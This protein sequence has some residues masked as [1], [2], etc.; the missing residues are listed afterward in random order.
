M[1]KIPPIANLQN[2]T[3]NPNRQTVLNMDRQKND[4]K[5]NRTLHTFG[6]AR[7]HKTAPSQNQKSAISPRHFNIQN[8]KRLFL[9][10][11]LFFA[12]ATAHSQNLSL[13]ELFALCNKPNWDEVN[14]YMLKKGW[15]Y[16][17]SSKGDDTPCLIFEVLK[18]FLRAPFPL[19]TRETRVCIGFLNWLKPLQRL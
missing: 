9:L 7:P 18:T 16:H 1:V 5:A 13:N 15:E 8:M 11:T 12:Y 17:E 4:I 6:F 10:V 19:L 14:E 2:V 3:S